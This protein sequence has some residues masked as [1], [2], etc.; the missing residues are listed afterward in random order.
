M[1]RTFGIAAFA[2]LGL[3]MLSGNATAKS[4]LDGIGPCANGSAQR[5]CGRS[6]RPHHPGYRPGK[7]R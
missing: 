6:Y 1:I 2:A 5:G 4:I 7:R 3:A